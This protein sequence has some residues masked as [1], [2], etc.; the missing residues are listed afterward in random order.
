MADPCFSTMET[1]TVHNRPV[2]GMPGLGSLEQLPRLDPSS[3]SK[4]IIVSNRLP[5]TIKRDAQGLYD[6]S[7][8]SGGLVSALSG[9]KKQMKFTWIGW[10]GLDVPEDERPQ[11]GKRLEAEFQCSPVYISDE[12]ADRHYNGFSNSILWPLFHYRVSPDCVGVKADMRSR[13]G[14]DV[15]Q[16]ARLACVLRSQSQVC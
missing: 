6:F 3:T 10:P 7:M 15:F 16:R 13:Q 8:S 4:L 14:R 12:V 1:P 9:C 2:S 5:I 11:L